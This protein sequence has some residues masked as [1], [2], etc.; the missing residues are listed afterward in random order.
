MGERTSTWG[1]P[2]ERESELAA[3]ATA[4]EAPC[5]GSGQLIVVEGGAGAGKSTLLDA[6]ARL[7]AEGGLAVLRARGGELERAHPFGIVRQLFEPPLRRRD[8]DDRSDLLGGAARP[9]A[10]LLGLDDAAGP[11]AD[12]FAAAHAIFW[13]VAGLSARQPLLIAIDDA[14]WGDYSSLKAIEHLA[15][16]ID[17]LPVALLLTQRPMEPGAPAA[18]LDALRGAA[19]AVRLD[20]A[21]LSVEAV[22]VLVRARWPESDDST[23]NACQEATGGNPLLLAELLRALAAASEPPGVAEVN[24]ASIAT[25]EERALRR[26]GR[27]APEASRLAQTMSVLGDG[28]PLAIA[29]DLAGL[30][31]EVASELALGLRRLEVLAVEDPV[32]FVHPLV[33]RSLYDGLAVP[34]RHRL[35]E[36]AAEL[37]GAAGAEVEACAS[38]LAVL[39]PSGS[40]T[41]AV[42]QLRAGESALDRA[43]P[44][45]AITWLER[46]LAEEAPQPPR[47]ILLAR[48]GLARTALRDPAAIPVLQEAYHG[49]LD[50][51]LRLAVAS[52]LAYGLGT[53]GAWEQAA[54]VID[55]A[56][57][58]LGDDQQARAGLAAIRATMERHDPQRVA[59]FD[60]RRAE[61]E[62]LARGESA[63]AN[64]LAT[65]LAAA[66]V[67]EG[68]VGAARQQLSLARR[69]ERLLRDV[70][71]GGWA[72]PLLLMVPI[73]LDD[74]ADAAALI[75]QTKRAAQASASALHSLTASACDAWLQARR[76]DLIGAQADLNPLLELSRDAGMPM[77]TANVA[78][79]LID[80]LIERDA[81]C[82]AADAIDQLQ[83]PPELL[84]TWAGAMLLE[85]LGRLRLAR[86]RREAGIGDLLA[87]GQTLEALRVGPL[88]SC[89]R[90]E[91]ALAIGMQEPGEA[92]TLVEAELELARSTGLPRPRGVALRALGSLRSRDD[93]GITRLQESVAILRDG[94]S[95]LEHARSM[96]ALGGALRRAGRRREARAVLWPGLEL[97]IACGAD[98]LRRSAEEE[99][100]A[101]GS[102]RTRPGPTGAQA[103]TASETRVARLAAAGHSNVDIAQRLFVSVKTVE[104]HLAHVY[105]KLGLS[106]AGSRWRLPSIL[107]ENAGSSEALSDGLDAAFPTAPT[108]TT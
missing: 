35:H 53:A 38:H 75:D 12:A 98:R 90:S 104:T 18:L 23:V 40:V 19:G 62:G 45:E 32:T 61:L 81:A 29:A 30:E 3:L 27:V 24:T 65:V 99:L 102:R 31:G 48:L 6:A 51:E 11:V 8:P 91:L 58:D 79:F 84:A 13:L 46:G 56:D 92:L 57:H 80:V 82:P 15:R 100:R 78:H 10:R 69:G 74:M 36:R 5:A 71:A 4:L 50:S 26:A 59:G 95:R 88:V 41:V 60:A 2:L 93:E 101:A 86:G 33:R 14:H 66:A 70:A 63:G 87:A 25:L 17:D 42:H 72:V 44:D 47:A 94:P 37:L 7:A 85:S 89:W 67:Y 54:A 83:I 106:G 43:A 108:D 103:L 76:G 107:D 52:E 9:A 64:A 55:R 96:V 77:M 22:S 105:G 97:A 1:G 68:R 28:A 73:M 16:R 20:P 39:P 49:G 21:P 34:D